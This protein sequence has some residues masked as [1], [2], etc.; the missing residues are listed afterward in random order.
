ME[1][2]RRENYFYPKLKNGTR[3]I[4]RVVFSKRTK[5]LFITCSILIIF[6]LGI[7]LGLLIFG[8]FGTFDNPSQKAIDILHFL[9][10]YGL[11]NFKF[12]LEGVLKE[13][14]RIPLNYIRGQFSKP[15]R[16]YIDIG[17]EDYRKL[18]YLR[19]KA[20][21]KGMLTSEEKEY[22]PARISYNDKVVNVKLRL[23][24]DSADHWKGNKWSFRIKVKG[25]ETLFG[26]KTFSIQDPKT[27]EYLN[28]F[29]Y[30]T[31]LKREGVMAL[32]YKFI[33]VFVNGE[34]KGIYA[35]EEHF[36]KELIENNSRRE[37]VIVK[38]NEDLIVEE[39][40]L[41]K[42]NFPSQKELWLYFDNK[43]QD[44][45]FYRSEV[46]T[47]DN[48]KF[49]N[50]PIL[51]K[52][53]EEA[54]NLLESFREGSLKTREVFDVDKLAKYFA[55]TTL[56]S[57]SHGSDWAA[58]RFYYNPITARLEPIG[59]DASSVRVNT[60]E[61]IEEYL[62]PCIGYGDS[63]QLKEATF[64]DLIFRDEV[65][66]KKY[67][68]ELK[69]ISEKS[70]LDNLFSDID[71]ELK[72]NK[73]IIHKDAPAYHFDKEFYYNSQKQIQ[74]KLNP[75]KSINAYM[76]ESFPSQNKLVLKIGNV[77][78]LPLEIINLV[79]NDT[80]VFE[81]I[82]GDRFMQPKS[83]RT[84]VDYKSF[85]F[86]IPNN[87]EWSPN[88]TQFL[89]VNYRIYGLEDIRSE[90]V[91]TWSYVQDNFL[92][93]DFLR[94]K[95]VSNSTEFLEINNRT[96]TIYFKKGI[97]T[98]NQ[99]LIIPPDFSVF[100]GPGT[101]INLV[102]KA[103]IISYSDLQIQGTKEEPVRIISSDGSGQG[104]AVFNTKKE[105][106]LKYV[107]FQNLSNP[108]KYNWELTGAITFYESQVKFSNVLILGMRSEDSLN[109]VNSKFGI[110]NTEFRD[111]FSDCLDVDF[112]E[113]TIESTI[114]YNSGND[115]LDFSGSTIEL[116]NIN[117]TNAGDKGISGGERSNIHAENIY[118]N[119]GFIGIASKDISYIQV[120]KIQISNTEY[121][122]AV[123]QK[124]PEFGPASVT[125]VETTLSSNKNNYII[126]K[127]STL[128]INGKVILDGKE[129]VYE[130]LY[131]LGS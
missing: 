70:Y 32:R 98:I 85:E 9:G 123:Y 113:G 56:L 51:S 17:F 28:E 18:E 94:Q 91:F 36:E 129:N 100:I 127:Q 74:A 57:A 86:T 49:L 122:F 102:N 67:M 101:I 5:I 35:V 1:I 25:G 90:K 61:I 31:A 11:K 108:S 124:K 87:F 126:E 103:S 96:N 88:I 106:N 121:G 128:S 71:E 112:G 26:M 40:M 125:T 105:S 33:E 58:I 118:I 114:L 76:Q 93:E 7:F 131:F 84:A 6:F 19:E 39:N 42:D 77:D 69:R 41:V 21:E 24:G 82:K 53:F 95:P 81:M 99:S 63:C 16:I 3:K 83:A 34:N 97:W 64:H 62:P 20:I 120:N 72:R 59:F 116:S 68:Q 78:Y 46:E 54:K 23:K 79:Y 15:E 65:F 115:C 92:E 2:K 44:T 27:R 75:L 117:I 89:K 45:Q 4:F 14:V 130:I 13:N 107:I 48:E 110:K 30:H 29:I 104:I 12:H 109:I 43:I 60:Y 66:F 119:K 37:G 111:C 47:F 10:F 50:D 80:I 38:F 22:V 8:F 55:V 52:Q 73:N